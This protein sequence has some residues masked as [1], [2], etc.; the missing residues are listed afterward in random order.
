MNDRTPGLAA[1]VDILQRAFEA[2]EGE[3]MTSANVE[4]QEVQAFAEYDKFITT[5]VGPMMGPGG[6]G[7]GDLLGFMLANLAQD[8]MLVITFAAMG[9]ARVYELQQTLRELSPSTNDSSEK[10]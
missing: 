5:V 2:T 1:A 4:E 3:D 6:D 8:P 10:G 7:M 9:A